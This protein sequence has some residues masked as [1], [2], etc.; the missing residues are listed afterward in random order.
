MI[1][2]KLKASKMTIKK[3]LYKRRVCCNAECGWTGK[4][5]KTV[6]PKHWAS[7]RLCPVCHEVTEPDDN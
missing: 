5:S 6:H 2:E 4:E 1:T 3:R 7:D